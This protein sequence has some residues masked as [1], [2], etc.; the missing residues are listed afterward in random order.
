MRN[1]VFV[2]V[3]HATASLKLYTLTVQSLSP[4]GPTMNQPSIVRKME[5]KRKNKIKIEREKKLCSSC[6]PV[7]VL[8]VAFI[9]L[10]TGRRIKCEI[11][12]IYVL[13]CMR[14][15]KCKS[16][17]SARHKVNRGVRSVIALTS[18]KSNAVHASWNFALPPQ[19]A[20]SYSGS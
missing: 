13:S 6:W 4:N 16:V 1:E 3:Q 10:F 11:A 7:N 14:R 19:T 17:G 5:T 20:E 2:L 15:I 18:P 12:F 8:L 9:H